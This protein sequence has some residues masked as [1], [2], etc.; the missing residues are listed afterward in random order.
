MRPSSLVSV[1]V[2]CFCAGCGAAV[3]PGLA[4]APGLGGASPETR[5]HDAIA[6]GHDA[7]ERS[8]FPQGEVLRGHIPPCGKESR[9][10][11]VGFVPPAPKA[12]P[13][14]SR[15]YPFG[16]CPA[17]RH[18]RTMGSEKAMAAYPLSAQRW[19]LLCDSPWSA[20][21]STGDPAPFM[22]D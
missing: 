20:T 21:P 17:R 4:N 8:M 14:L 15:P 11:I 19:W 7:C 6:N 3:Q 10:K 1:L 5:V 2:C 22:G 13:P 18:L 12:E 16:V 9:A